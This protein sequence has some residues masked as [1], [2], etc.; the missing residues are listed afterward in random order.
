MFHFC[1]CFS[2]WPLISYHWPG[3]PTSD[4]LLIIRWWNSLSWCIPTEGMLLDSRQRD[5]G[6]FPLSHSKFDPLTCI[7]RGTHQKLRFLEADGVWPEEL[8]SSSGFRGFLA[9]TA[10]GRE[11]LQRG[12]YGRRRE[13]IASPPH[14]S[15]MQAVAQSRQLKMED[16]LDLN[17]KPGRSREDRR[18]K[19]GNLL[20][21][22]GI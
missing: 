18:T 16:H 15:Q 14:E 17:R 5:L 9:T 19:G 13:G 4:A 21:G 1:Y 8:K 22:C 6:I 7:S 12:D 10:G 3:L 20:Y 2:H 11:S